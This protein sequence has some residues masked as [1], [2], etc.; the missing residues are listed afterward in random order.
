MDHRGGPGT[1][2]QINILDKLFI[3][4]AHVRPRV[5]RAT[6]SGSLGKIR[7]RKREKEFFFPLL[8]RQKC[9]SAGTGG[10]SKEINRVVMRHGNQRVATAIER[11]KRRKTR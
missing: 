2:L 1:C 8:R 9:G 6:K 5:S 11:E 10:G 4:L 3:E 7:K